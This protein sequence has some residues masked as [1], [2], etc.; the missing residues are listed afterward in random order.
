MRYH[1]VLGLKAQEEM[2]MKRWKE[3]DM[4]QWLPLFDCCYKRCKA[5]GVVMWWW[6]HD[7]FFLCEDCARICR[8]AFMYT[9]E[10]KRLSLWWLSERDEE[11]VKWVD[12]ESGVWEHVRK[13]YTRP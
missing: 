5:Y 12:K 13:P 8:R 7:V 1:G 6:M 2:A 4:R 3:G 11:H 10:G 9:K